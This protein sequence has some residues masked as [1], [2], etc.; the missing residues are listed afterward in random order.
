MSDIAIAEGWA[1]PDM[2]GWDA[3]AANRKLGKRGTRVQR[4]R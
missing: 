1:N 4:K 2:E 3:E